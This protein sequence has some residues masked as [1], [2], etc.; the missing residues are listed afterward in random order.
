MMFSTFA[1]DE[2]LR[3]LTIAF[4][5]NET[6]CK[7]ALKEFL[8]TDEDKNLE[9]ELEKYDKNSLKWAFYNGALEAENKTIDKWYKQIVRAYEHGYLNGN[10]FYVSWN[11]QS[12]FFHFIFFWYRKD[13]WNMSICLGGAFFGLLPSFLFA[14]AF[15]YP[16]IIDRFSIAVARGIIKAEDYY[17]GEADIDQIL[18]FLSFGVGN[19]Y[20]MEA[21]KE[22]GGVNKWATYFVGVIIALI[23]I[24]IKEF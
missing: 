20:I 2:A 8:K 23:F 17:I 5:L 18:D 4:L 7:K 24:A 3:N 15:G 6:A 10:W 13:Y 12:F 19:V 16:A 14:G 22:Y 11:W 21:V 9:E 1:R